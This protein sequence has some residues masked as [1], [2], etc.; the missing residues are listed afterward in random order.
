[1]YIR[2]ST[3]KYSGM[4]MKYISK[5]IA[6][7]Y[8]Y[9]NFKKYIKTISRNQ[10]VQ[11]KLKVIQFFDEH[12]TVVTKQAFE[13]SRSTVY[14][15]K[16]RY[17]DAKYDLESLL[18]RSRAPKSIRKMFVDPKIL[19]F[20]KSQRSAHNIG[21]SKLKVLLDEFCDR[22][23]LDTISESKIGKI[24]NRYNI[25]APKSNEYKRRIKYKKKRNRISSRYKP[26]YPGELVQIDTI[27]R[28]DLNLKR[29]ILT[30]IDI[31][32]RYAFAFTFNKLSSKTALDFMKKLEF[33]APFEI[34][35]VKT[36]NGSEFLALF[37]DY[38]EQNNIKHFF[39]YPK[40]PK[41]N[42]YV[43]RFNR[44]LQDE[45]VE[46]SLDFIEYIPEFNQKLC[47]YLIKYNTI[48][49]HH[50]IKNKTPMS[51][52]IFEGVLSRMSVTYTSS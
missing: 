42:A 28:Y 2:M 10:I 44:T 11:E 32:S 26:K 23:C 38:L 50:G 37:D 45:F 20:I 18:P 8:R 35:A 52:L 40:T 49:P 16:K 47:E 14:E 36:D 30:A 31:Y 33:S 21:K 15:W 1:M 41:S 43:E 5:G 29:Y 22:E 34:K 46:Y 25:N 13:V 6:G 27:V 4:R 48:R 51:V 17:R 12:G 19:E 39:T 9:M 7:Y 3:G 24:L